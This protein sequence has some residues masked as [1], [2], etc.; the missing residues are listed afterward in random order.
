MIMKTVRLSLLLFHS[1]L[2][3]DV[4]VSQQPEKRRGKETGRTLVKLDSG[5]R[6]YEL[7][8]NGKQIGLG[9]KDANWYGN[10]FLHI[11]IDGKKSSESDGVLS[12]VKRGPKVGLVNVTWQSP[13]GPVTALFE[14]RDRDDKLLVTLKLPDAKSRS[15][16][17]QCY[18]SSFAGGYRPGKDTRKRHTVTANREVV[19][20]NRNNEDIML[21]RE[22]PWALFADD[23]FDF[24]LKRGIGPCAA[25]YYPH[26]TKSA[27]ARTSNYASYLIL[28]PL[29][30]VKEVHLVLWDF[31]GISNAKAI[32][33]MK[34]LELERAGK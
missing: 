5:T 12:V 7:R 20:G 33:Y 19:L 4:S 10:G 30:D 14:L 31:E 27:K 9:P 24:A 21:T 8:F 25:L 13:G 18:P 2:H 16:Q 6:I 22:E 32:E 28:Q 17:L 34:A 15:I 23:H 3:A 11:G 29:E 26:E 1:V